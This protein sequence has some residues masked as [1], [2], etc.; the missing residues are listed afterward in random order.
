MRIV[1]VLPVPLWPRYPKI[2]PSATL[3]LLPSTARTYP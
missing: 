1:V 2:S 3:K